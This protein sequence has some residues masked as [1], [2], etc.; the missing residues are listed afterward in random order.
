MTGIVAG[1]VEITTGDSIMA[2]ST[3][4][5]LL[6]NGNKYRVVSELKKD[7]GKHE[8]GYRKTCH[9]FTLVRCE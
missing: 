4:S 5:S 7:V 3:G 9:V 2:L 1:D 6:I 8:C